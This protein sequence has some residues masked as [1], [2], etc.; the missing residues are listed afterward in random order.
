MKAHLAESC[1]LLGVLCSCNIPWEGESLYHQASPVLLYS[2]KVVQL[3]TIPGVQEVTEYVVKSLS[4]AH[5]M[6]YQFY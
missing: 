1:R 6:S 4:H 2:T 3:N 5:A